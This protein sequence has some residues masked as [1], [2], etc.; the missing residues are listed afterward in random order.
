[1]SQRSSYRA[2]LWRLLAA[3]ACHR[4]LRSLLILDAEPQLLDDAAT[5]YTTNIAGLLS[6]FVDA[7]PIIDGRASEG[8]TQLT[9]LDF[10]NLVSQ[11]ASIRT[12][13]NAAGADTLRAK[14]TVRPP[15][16]AT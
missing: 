10:T 14:W 5:E 7:D 11:I 16:I 4:Q 3:I 15:R 8:V 6:G 13:I 1:M 9:K 2:P 12:E